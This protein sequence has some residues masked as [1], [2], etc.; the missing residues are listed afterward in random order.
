M[1]V[2]LYQGIQI[3]ISFEGKT[4]RNLGLF[5][6][7]FKTPPDSPVQKSN[8]L[9]PQPPQAEAMLFVYGQSALLPPFLA[10]LRVPEDINRMDPMRQMWGG[11]KCR[12]GGSMNPRFP[13]G[14]LLKSKPT[15]WVWKKTT[16][17]IWGCED[18]F[19]GLHGGP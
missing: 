12:G 15:N 8:P 10:A 3:A 11:V 14:S 5:V 2:S 13:V 9:V 7:L 17:P 4:E 6:P 16:A 18:W 1:G 19:G